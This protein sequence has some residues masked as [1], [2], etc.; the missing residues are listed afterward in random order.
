MGAPLKWG[1]GGIIQRLDEMFWPADKIL[2]MSDLKRITI[3]GQY[4][5]NWD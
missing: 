5:G 4:R 2:C 3:F 1:A